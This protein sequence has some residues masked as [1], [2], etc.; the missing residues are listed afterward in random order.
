[1]AYV[2]YSELRNNLVKYIDQVVE[3]RVELHVSRQD[4]PGVVMLSEEE[5]EGWKEIVHLLNSPANAAR[6]FAALGV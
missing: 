1:M 6:I 4:R 5:S 3:D 2:T